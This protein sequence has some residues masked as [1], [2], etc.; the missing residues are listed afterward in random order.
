MVILGLW[1]WKG[2]WSRRKHTPRTSPGR[3]WL[4]RLCSAQSPVGEGEGDEGEGDEGEGDEGEG[5]E[6]E[7]DEMLEARTGVRSGSNN[8]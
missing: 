1:R 8:P 6:G 5:D 3:L 7:G 2:R 4:C